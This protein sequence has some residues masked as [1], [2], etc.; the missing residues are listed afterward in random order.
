MIV[1]MAARRAGR[2][3]RHRASTTSSQSV[4]GRAVESIGDVTA[5][6]RSLDPGRTVVIDLRRGTKARRSCASSSGVR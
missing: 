3:R 5:L 1:E 6:V 4:N 2:A